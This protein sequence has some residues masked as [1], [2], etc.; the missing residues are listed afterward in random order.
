[1]PDT[2]S[3]P[4]AL[5]RARSILVKAEPLEASPTGIGHLSEADHRTLLLE[6]MVGT[7]AA[8]QLGG[9][10]QRII[11]WLAGWDND[12]VVTVASLLRRAFLAGEHNTRHA[13]PFTDDERN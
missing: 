9:Q 2:A 7:H 8:V 12:V 1:M 3:R 13:Q 5:D 11:D 6:A 10:D 4:G